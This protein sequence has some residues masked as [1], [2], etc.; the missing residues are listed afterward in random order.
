M[1]SLYDE[2]SPAPPEGVPT[3][4]VTI[5][6]NGDKRTVQARS[7]PAGLEVTAP[8][9]RYVAPADTVPTG[10]WNADILRRREAL[11]SNGKLVPFAFE[12]AGTRTV[13]VDGRPVEPGQVIVLRQMDDGAPGHAGRRR[14][15]R[16]RQHRRRSA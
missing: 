9:G 11:D 13:Q 14:P 16:D 6:V 1:T 10:Y 8:H 12:P 7:T 4:R 3:R 2:V 5:T 15:R